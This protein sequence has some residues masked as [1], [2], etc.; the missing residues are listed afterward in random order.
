MTVKSDRNPTLA[1]VAKRLDPNGQVDAIVELL[2]ETNEILADMTF[3]EGNLTDGH[4]T[5]IRTGLPSA[6]WRAFYQGVQPSKSTTAQVKD[7]CG[8]LETYAEI[9]KALA[10]LNGNTQQIRL[11]EDRAFMEAMNQEMASTVFY[12]NTATD[13]KKFMGLAPR[14]NSLSTDKNQIG[15]NVVNGGGSGSTNTSMWIVS[16]GANTAFGIYPKGSKAGFTRTDLGQNTKTESDGGQYEIYR[17]HYKWDAGLV[18]RDWR[19]ICRIA[20]IDTAAFDD[21]GETTY[22]G[23]N[24]VNLLIKGYHKVKRAGKIGRKA[25]YVNDTLYTA[26]DLFVA[27]KDNVWLTRKEYDGEDVT[28]FRGIP[29]RMVDALLDTEDTVA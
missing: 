23:A 28:M 8:M 4:K 10:D 14:F 3:M 29:I 27:N 6:T 19:A 2:S 16:W 26:L 11:T 15:Y 17:T 24:L 18:V 9:D 22:D 1:D 12:G 5:T 25:I 7:T 20:N 21:V 13:P